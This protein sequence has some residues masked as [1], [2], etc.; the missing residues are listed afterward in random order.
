MNDDDPTNIF[1]HMKTAITKRLLLDLQKD[2]KDL[3]KEQ[4]LFF[5]NNRV[6]ENK[7]WEEAVRVEISVEDILKNIF[8]NNTHKNK[9]YII[10]R[11]IERYG[12]D[13]LDNYYILIEYIKNIFKTKTNIITDKMDFMISEKQFEEIYQKVFRPYQTFDNKDKFKQKKFR[14]KKKLCKGCITKEDDY[15]SILFKFIVNNNI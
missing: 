11:L 2:F 13:K 14:L 1:K 12:E 15:E 8:T 4:L 6:N 3:S 9:Y 5:I 7:D 10:K